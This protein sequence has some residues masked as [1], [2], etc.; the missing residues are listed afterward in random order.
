MTI[1]LRLGPVPKQPLVRLTVTLTAEFKATLD[2]YAAVHAETT[3]E[4]HDVS[5]LIPH[6][7]AA[8]VSNDR[9][10]QVAARTHARSQNLARSTGV[11]RG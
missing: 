7:L 8:F 9:A 10:V 1:K 11:E 5:N 3:G 6:M 4:K 2:R